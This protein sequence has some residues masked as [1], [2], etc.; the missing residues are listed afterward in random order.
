MTCGYRSTLHRRLTKRVRYQPAYN[1]QGEHELFHVLVFL[2]DSTL[3][4]VQKRLRNPRKDESKK[5]TK[6]VFNH[7]RHL[8]RLMSLISAKHV[9]KIVS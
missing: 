8:L 6:N 9:K 4:S 1:N 7:V 5:T 2:L 3:T